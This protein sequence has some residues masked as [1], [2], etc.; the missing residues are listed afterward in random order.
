MIFV[1]FTR[2]LTECERKNSSEYQIQTNNLASSLLIYDEG[3][4]NWIRYRWIV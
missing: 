1:D 3:F 4:G 2:D